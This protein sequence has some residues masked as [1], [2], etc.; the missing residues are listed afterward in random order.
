MAD[1]L[2]LTHGAGSNRDAPLL[3]ALDE[4]LA[5]VGVL[6]IRVNLAFRQARPTGPPRQ[7]DAGRDRESLREA[8]DGASGGRIFLGGH[9]YGGR[10]SSILAAENPG[11]VSGLLLLSYPLHPP[12]NPNQVR[13]AHLPRLTTPAL[14]V[15]G[16]RDPFG[17]VEELRAAIALIPAATGLVEIPG[18]GH[19]L[20]ARRPFAPEP[21][22]NLITQEFLRFFKVDRG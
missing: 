10:Q 4:A 18:A 3:I 8:V 6:V 15:H 16:T 11:L 2:I 7:G 17:T 19:D 21:I 13:T 14:F 12:R 5:A 9:S 20:A 1:C 22:S